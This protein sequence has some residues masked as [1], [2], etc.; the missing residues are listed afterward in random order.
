MITR[1]ATK[2]KYIIPAGKAT[3]TP[4]LSTIFNQHN[5]RAIDF[6]G[7][8]SDTIFKNPKGGALGK[9]SLKH[10]YEIALI[11][12][13]QENMLDYELKDICKSLIE[14]SKSVGIEIVP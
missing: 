2:I 9:I 12:N 3:P 13:Q 11:K 5:R 10:V 14:A 4:P 8:N 1:K 6:L 7:I